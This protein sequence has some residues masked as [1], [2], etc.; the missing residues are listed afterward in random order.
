MSQGRFKPLPVGTGTGDVLA[1]VTNTDGFI[2]QWDGANSKTLKN[3]KAAP[4]GTIVGTTDSQVLTNKTLTSPTIN[5]P[6]I[7]TPAISNATLTTPK[8]ASGGAPAAANST[9]VAGTIAWDS[10][11]LYICI[12]TDTWKRVAIATWP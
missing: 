8:I 1:P 9:G 11:F 7:A 12:S 2:P 6:T 4:S 3:G 10:G 5:T